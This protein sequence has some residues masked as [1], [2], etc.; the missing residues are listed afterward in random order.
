MRILVAHNVDRRRTGGMSRIMEIIHDEV[1]A[2]G[3]IVEW[4]SAEDVPPRWRGSMVRAA[5][6][7]LVYQKARAAARAGVPYDIVNV[8]EPHGALVALAQKRVTRHGVVVTSHGVERRAWELALEER[9]LGRGG[10]GLRTRVVYPTTSLW[11]S[12]LALTCARLVLTLSDQDREY[13]TTHL[14]V[15]ASRIGRMRPGADQAFAAPATRRT[16]ASA[17]RLLFAGTWRHN[18]GI[19]D[20]VEAFTTL[21]RRHRTLSLTVLGAGVAPGVVAD[22]FPG[23]VRGRVST[24]P[25]ADDCGAVATLERADIFV[26]PSLF[27]GTPLTLIEAMMSGLPIVATA[28]CGIKDAVEADRSGLLIP[29]RSPAALDAAVERLLAS[30]PLRESLGRQ[31]HARAQ[32]EFTWP[33]VAREVLGAYQRLM[34]QDLRQA[35]VAGSAAG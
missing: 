19:V 26:L 20:L 9:R 35:S 14:G 25:N 13:L 31:A 18:K 27:E 23:D 10:P 5:F 2:Q 33:K 32:R 1:A 3:H 24:I 15:P 8:H 6:P 21:A 11:Q 22:A 28:T 17:D 7:W 16:Y 34:H 4:L 12:H 30:R 29:T